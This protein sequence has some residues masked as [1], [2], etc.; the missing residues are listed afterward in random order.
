MYCNHL[1]RNAKRKK[2]I[3]FQSLPHF[4]IPK[5]LLLTSGKKD[6]P[7]CQRVPVGRWHVASHHD[8]T[9]TALLS[10]RD[11][12]FRNGDKPLQHVF[13]A[14]GTSIES[15][16]ASSLV[17]GSLRSGRCDLNDRPFDLCQHP[18]GGGCFFCGSFFPMLYN[19]TQESRGCSLFHPGQRLFYAD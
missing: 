16:S 19:T 10:L 2:N 11:Q 12:L 3:F 14:F 1:E 13:M 4:S 9:C 18:G 7:S 8:Y 6:A 5:Q 15:S 17:A